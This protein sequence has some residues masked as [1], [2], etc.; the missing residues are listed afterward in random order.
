MKITV[1]IENT[2]NSDLIS[3][4]G[5]SLLIEFEEKK[6]LLDAGSTGAFLQNVKAMKLSLEDVEG[7]V[8]SHG[9]YDHAGGFGAY[10]K[11]NPS[12]KVYA[13]KSVKKEYYSGSGGSIHAI[14]VPQEILLAYE[15]QFVFIEKVTSLAERVYL[16]PHS[17]KGLETIGARTKLYRKQDNEYV[18]D[19]FSHELSLVFE[20][21]EGLFIF[22]SCSHGDIRNII[23]EVRTVFPEKKIYG[24]CGGLHMKGK[25]QGAEY[26][27]FSK[28]EVKSIADYLKE[29]GLKKLY[30]GH[31]TGAEGLALLKEFLGEQVEELFTGK[32][33]CIQKKN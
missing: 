25:R 28:E 32:E 5:L 29:A 19:D 21:E 14:G 9:H 2:T 13:M 31:C 22:N 26:C 15:K 6:Y 24:F 17:T 20:M 33:I 8:L 7:A 18:P 12:V 10:L 4:H 11:E 30:T 3:E 16:I 27:T 1:L 23:E